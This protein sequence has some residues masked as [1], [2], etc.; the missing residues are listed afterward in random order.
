MALTF[1][2]IVLIGNCRKESDYLK[3]FGCKLE[4]YSTHLLFRVL[5]ASISPRAVRAAWGPNAPLLMGKMTWLPVC[6]F[7]IKMTPGLCYYLTPVCQEEKQ[8]QRA[9]KQYSIGLD[10]RLRQF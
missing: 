3:K 2:I 7:R 1:A 6:L 10:H 9:K 8:T 4:K 5:Y